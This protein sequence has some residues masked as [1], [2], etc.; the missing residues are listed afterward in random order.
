MVENKKKDIDGRRYHIHDKFG[1]TKPGTIKGI[2][3]KIKWNYKSNKF[4]T[5]EGS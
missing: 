3:L 1:S 4:E 5:V 2:T